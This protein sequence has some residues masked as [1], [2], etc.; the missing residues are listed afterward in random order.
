MA[1]KDLYQKINAPTSVRPLTGQECVLQAELIG[2]DFTGLGDT[3]DVYKLFKL[4]KFQKVTSVQVTVVN[5]DDSATAVDIGYTDGTNTDTDYFSSA[6][7]I[8]ASANILAAIVDKGMICLS[9]DMYIVIVPNDTLQ[10]DTRFI[11]QIKIEDV[12]P[13]YT[14][15]TTSTTAPITQ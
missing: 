9:N 4:Q 12:T 15:T 11:V 14:L 13:A 7:D 3:T 6:V 1:N 2:T 8:N 5:L 10:S